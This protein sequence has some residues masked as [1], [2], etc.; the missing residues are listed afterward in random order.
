[1]WFILLLNTLYN[2]FLTNADYRITDLITSSLDINLAILY[3][4][5]FYFIKYII[6]FPYMN[7][8]KHHFLYSYYL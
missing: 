8:R 1:M 2:Q 5:Y 3:C 7:G 6:Q 4:Y